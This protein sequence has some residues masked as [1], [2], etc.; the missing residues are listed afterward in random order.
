MCYTFGVARRRILVVDDDPRILKRVAGA[1][2]REGF[3]VH[4][5]RHAAAALRMAAKIRP[6]LAILDVTMP[7]MNGFDLAERIRSNA[8]TAKTRCMFLTAE[9]V[10][11]HV[12]EAKEAGAIA[13]LEKPFKPEVLL[14]VVGQLLDGARPDGNR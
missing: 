11:R 9:Q 5:T 1:L 7:E 3:E 13:Y 10:S 2:E 4:S 6:A 14:R 8:R 12:D